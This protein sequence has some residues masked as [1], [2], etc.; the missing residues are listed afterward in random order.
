MNSER[1]ESGQPPTSAKIRRSGHQ[2]PS[3]TVPWRPT[4]NQPSHNMKKLLTAI[5]S[6][7]LVVMPLALTSTEAAAKT[8]HSAKA[9]GK[10]AKKA[11]KHAKKAKGKHAKHAKSAH[12]AKARTF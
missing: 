5:L 6:A 3:G 10:H 9:S 1:P 4:L 12:K 2:Q 7:A 8:P 11:G